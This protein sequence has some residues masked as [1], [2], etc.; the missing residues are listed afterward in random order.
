MSDVTTHEHRE[1]TYQFL[2]LLATYTETE[3][4]INIGAYVKGSNPK[5]DKV[6]SLIESMRGF[7][8]QGV[9]EKVT[10][11]ESMNRLLSL[12]NNN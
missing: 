3:D 10:V 9:D 4:L 6:L 1:L 8:K 5:V 7:L 2:D 11:E 12:L